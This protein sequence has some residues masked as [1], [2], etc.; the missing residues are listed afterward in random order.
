MCTQS[1]WKTL[2]IIYKDEATLWFLIE[3]ELILLEPWARR[4]SSCWVHRQ[5]WS[6]LM[7]WCFKWTHLVQGHV[8]VYL[9][10]RR[11]SSTVKKQARHWLWTR[12]FLAM[13]TAAEL[14]M[15][16]SQT[17]TKQ[18]Y[19]SLWTH[20]LEPLTR[21]ARE[22]HGPHEQRRGKLMIYDWLRPYCMRALFTR[23]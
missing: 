3:C 13:C 6:K 8:S 18:A 2:L 12:F 11:S 7:I 21:K 10:R 23:R 9:Q 17:K 22:N 19:D 5:W 16:S 14:V 20:L 15:Q 4:R 1:S